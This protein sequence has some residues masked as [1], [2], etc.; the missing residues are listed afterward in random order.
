MDMYVRMFD[1]LKRNKGD[2]PTIGVILCSDK[3]DTIVKFSF[4]KESKQ[5]FVSKYKSYLP[6]EKELSEE[7]EKQK[8]ILR[9]QIEP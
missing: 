8:T 4:L 6:T 3:E 7:I 9:L 1:E 2:N 5:L